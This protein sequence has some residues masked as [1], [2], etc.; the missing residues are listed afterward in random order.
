MVAIAVMSRQSFRS[1]DVRISFLLALGTILLYW[2]LRNFPFINYD[3]SLYVT[4]NPHVQQGFTWEGITWAFSSLH[5]EGTYWHPLTWLSHMFDCQLFGVNPGPAHLV[6]ALFHSANVVLLFLLLRN[7]SA[8]TYLAAVVAAFFSV[9]PLQVDTVSWIAERKNLLSG[10][11]AL[12]TLCAYLRY[13]R[14]PQIGRYLLALV[15][16]ALALMAK[17]SVVTLPGLF[18]LLDWWPLQRTNP[19]VQSSSSAKKVDFR[20]LVLEKIP[21]FLL[22]VMSAVI[23]VWSHRALDALGTSAAF[24]W[25]SRFTNAIV[26]YFLYLKRIVWPVDL[27]IYYPYAAHSAVTVVGAGLVLAILTVVT[28][29][30]RRSRPWLLIGWLWFLLGLLPV[31]GLVQA[32]RQSMADRFVY[33]PIV[34]ALLLLITAAAEWLNRMHQGWIKAGACAVTLGACAI[35]AR[36]QIGYW[37][38]S[39]VLFEHAL[40]VTRQNDIAAL[41][42]GVA[43][44]SEQQYDEA[45]P[46]F[47]QARELNPRLALAHYNIGV[48]RAHQKQHAAAITEYER[49]LLLKPN[50]PRTHYNLGNA[51]LQ[52]GRTTEAIAAYYETLKWLPND[53]PA[54][55]N[56]A[57]ALASV[58][59]GA[60]AEEHFQKAI[61]AEPTLTDARFNLAVLLMREGKVDAAVGQL[62][63]LLK[64]DP[65]QRTARYQLASNL[66]R[67]HQYGPA[68][69][70]LRVLLE[71]A[72]DLAALGL[73]ARILATAS[74]ATV[75][76]G[77]DAMRAAERACQATQFQ[78]PAFLDTLA[79]SYAESGR[80][81]EAV[82]TAE[83]AAALARTAGKTNLANEIEKRK[84]LFTA[85]KPFHENE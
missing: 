38:S 37:R 40:Q 75:R 14:K 61:V 58:G 7:L 21:F 39:R 67:M 56:L 13:T 30:C 85:G 70:E 55:N 6:N 42:L 18:L 77:A 65:G 44:V 66:A 34:G 9:H 45:L 25:P 64:T 17:P 8:G 73:Y 2:P 49:A 50:D 48:I 81:P 46:Y 69:R 26:S 31:I 15:C 80:F 71:K 51:L 32:G 59:R 1:W 36:H 28:L 60:E 83:K 54:H 52:T 47:E 79:A 53:A 12:S 41:N 20:F 62:Q 82:S 11:F 78:N 27:A 22:S 33:L 35:T 24:P 19:A 63:E 29:A 16:F 10:F 74:D 3:D 57:N 72:N 4:E 68:L 76:N 5:G 23:T 43:L 84:A